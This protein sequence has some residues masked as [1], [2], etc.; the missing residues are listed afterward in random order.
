ME[1]FLLKVPL[2]KTIYSGSKQVVDTFT[3]AN[4]ANFQSVVIVE[5]PRKG[6]YALGF[7]TGRMQDNSGNEYYRVFIPTSPNPTTGFLEIV[8]TAEVR[9]AGVSVEDGIRIII[10]GGI[11]GPSSLQGLDNMVKQ[12]SE[13]SAYGHN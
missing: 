1:G 12:S 8:N 11:L 10:S 9:N 2:L 6:M 3:A 13:A 5:F 7:V 4:S